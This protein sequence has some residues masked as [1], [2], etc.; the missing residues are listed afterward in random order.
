M[1]FI[2]LYIFKEKANLFA[3]EVH[4]VPYNFAISFDIGMHMQNVI[5]MS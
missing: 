1:D 4:I 3:M 2:K 5:Y